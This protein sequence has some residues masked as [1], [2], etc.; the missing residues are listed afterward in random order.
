MCCWKLDSMIKYIYSKPY[1]LFL[2][3]ITI[4]LIIG[5]INIKEMLD[6]NI[7]DTYLVISYLDFALLSSFIYGALGLIYFALIRFN[8][9]LIKWMTIAHVIISIGGYCSIASF[10][11]LIRETAPG[12]FET[13]LDDMHFNERIN[14]GIFIT[15]F[16]III[17]QILFFINAIYALIKGRR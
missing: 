5:F 14:W 15:S 1:F 8:L 6:I 9:S 7:H 12:D 17:T 16:I 13:L 4:L 3:F 10:F 2:A 11:L